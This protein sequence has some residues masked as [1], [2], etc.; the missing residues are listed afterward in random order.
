M[1]IVMYNP[2][3]DLILLLEK[4]IWFEGKDDSSPLY[5]IKLS[6]LIGSFFCDDEF[7][8]MLKASKKRGYVK[9]GEL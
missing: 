5:G 6:N 8:D 7:E 9:I 4:G 1:N 3:L 2:K